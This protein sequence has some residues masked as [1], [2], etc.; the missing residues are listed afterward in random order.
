DKIR[1]NEPL[2]CR[3]VVAGNRGFP[4]FFHLP[5]THFLSTRSGGS[6]RSCRF[7]CGSSCILF[8]SSGRRSCF[9]GFCFLCR[10][11]RGGFSRLG[12][13][14]FLHGGRCFFFGWPRGWFSRPGWFFLC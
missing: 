9:S 6:S 5:N 8:L 1:S 14:R 10:S 11:W 4:L 3:E 7:G 13:W 12:S 2:D